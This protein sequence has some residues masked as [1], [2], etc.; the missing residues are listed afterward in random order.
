MIEIATA[1]EQMRSS[2]GVD[3]HLNDDRMD[4]QRD[5]RD[6]GVPLSMALNGRKINDV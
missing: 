1:A 2:S 6:V 5:I 3:L 4:G